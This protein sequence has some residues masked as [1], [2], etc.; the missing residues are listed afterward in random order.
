MVNEL[1]HHA[2]PLPFVILSAVFSIGHQFYLI[3][4]AQNVG[5]FFEQVQAVTLKAVISVKGFV[6]FL[7][8]DVGIFLQNAISASLDPSK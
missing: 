4:E 8:H 6:G 3:G 2:V 1:P 5:E 7:V